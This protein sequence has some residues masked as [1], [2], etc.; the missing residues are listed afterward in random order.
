VNIDLFQGQAREPLFQRQAPQNRL[1]LLG[2]QVFDVLFGLIASVVVVRL[3]HGDALPS[4]ISQQVM[5]A[6]GRFVL[7]GDKGGRKCFLSEIA[8]FSGA[9][10]P[11][12]AVV[13]RLP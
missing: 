3:G 13:S 11:L 7:S 12:P 1:P 9:G 8:R 4:V 6:A 5:Q 10:Q 2:R